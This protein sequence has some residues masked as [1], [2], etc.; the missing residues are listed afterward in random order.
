MAQYDRLKDYLTKCE[1]TDIVLT[2]KKINEILSSEHL[3]ASAYEYRAWWANSKSNPQSS[4]WLDAG[5]GV[6]TVNL[7][8]HEVAFTKRP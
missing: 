3:P 8:H 7:L 1:G 4:A 5:W 2:F 6:A